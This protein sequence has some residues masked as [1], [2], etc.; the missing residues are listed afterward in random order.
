MIR[1]TILSILV[2]WI[3]DYFCKTEYEEICSDQNNLDILASFCATTSDENLEC[4][5]YC[6]KIIIRKICNDA[7]SFIF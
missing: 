2:K 1:I 3:S 7:E 6:L 4:K 5:S